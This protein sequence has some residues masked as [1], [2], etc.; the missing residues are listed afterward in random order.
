MS[1]I[2]E[3]AVRRQI[4][5]LFAEAYEVGLYDRA[6]DRMIIKNYSRDQLMNSVR[7][8]RYQNYN[9]RDI[10]IRPS[11]STGYIFV[12]DM[13]IGQIQMIEADGLRFS[14]IVESSPLN[15]HGW[16]W[17]SEKPLEPNHATWFAQHIAIK[18]G[19]DRAS[20]DWRHFGRLAGFTNRKRQYVD[21]HGNLP[22]V[23]IYQ[24][25]KTLVKNGFDYVARI[26]SKKTEEEKAR[27]NTVQDRIIRYESTDHEERAAVTYKECIA[28]AES[29]YGN[30]FNSSVADWQ[31]VN[32]LI[33][34]GFSNEIIEAVLYKHSK[35]VEKRQGVNQQKYIDRTLQKAS[36]LYTC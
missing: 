4:D 8:L 18:Y 22:F 10:Y 7:Y 14:L 27:L 35:S 15:Y 24:A 9:E 6:G 23:K 36:D 12:D 3:N 16:L 28:R 2:T 21:D 17:M 31:A 32:R 25:E 5:A 13:S 33:K 11:G 1:R 29:H 30:E 34:I 26:I 19:T 20:S